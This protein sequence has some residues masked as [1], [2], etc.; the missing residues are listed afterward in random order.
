MPANH[1]PDNR[2]SDPYLLMLARGGYMVEALAKARYPATDRGQGQVYRLPGAPRSA[3]WR[4]ATVLSTWRSV[5]Y[6]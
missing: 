6:S 4:N 2:E 5:L 1:Y 3:P